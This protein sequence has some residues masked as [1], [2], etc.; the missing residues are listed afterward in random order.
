MLS[1]TE[2]DALEDMRDNIARAMRF[3][4][5]FD[6]DAFL[7]DDK[8][9]YARRAVSNLSPRLR[10]VCRLPSRNG[11]PKSPGNRLPVP[12]ASTATTMRTSKSCESGRRFTKPCP[13][14]TLSWT[15]SCTSD[16]RLRPR[17]DRRP[18]PRQPGNASASAV[19]AATWLRP[20]HAESARVRK[21]ASR[22]IGRGAAL[23]APEAMANGSHATLVPRPP[24]S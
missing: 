6:L 1:D 4:D 15:P 11:F 24:K 5:G 3:V 22:S 14:F 17:L 20:Q 7:A 23:I 16:L 13:R 2:R 10:A 19:L 8:T 18:R 9:F 21:I 12:A